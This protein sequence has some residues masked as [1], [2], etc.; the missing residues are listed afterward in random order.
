MKAGKEYHLIEEE[1]TWCPVIRDYRRRFVG[2]FKNRKQ[3]LTFCKK[4]EKEKPQSRFFVEEKLV[5]TS[6][7]GDWRDIYG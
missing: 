4:L 7:Y 1:R 2:L 5:E 6:P 3:A